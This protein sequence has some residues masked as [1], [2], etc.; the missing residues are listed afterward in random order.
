MNGQ[1]LKVLTVDD[2]ADDRYLLRINLEHNGCVVI[3]AANGAEGLHLASTCNPDVIISDALMP[4][5]D[6]FHLLRCIKTEES[7]QSIPFI[8]YSAV[9]TGDQEASLAISLGAEA[10]IAKPKE[11][12][13]FWNELQRVLDECKG[14][15]GLDVNPRMMEKKAEDFLQKYSSIVTA[16]LEEKVRE[17]EEAKSLIEEKE[18]DWQETFDAIEG[19]VSINSLDNN[20][21]LANRHCRT[22]L[23]V[24]SDE[25]YSHKCFEL[26]HGTSSPIEDCPMISVMESGQTAEIERFETKLNRWISISCFP[27]RNKTGEVRGVVH[28]A[29]DITDRKNNA[30]ALERSET[31]FRSTFEQAAVGI[32]H[33]SLDGRYIRVNK[34]FSDITGYTH[35]E[36]LSLNYKDVTF[37]DDIEIDAKQRAE[38]I[39]GNLESASV[40]K[41]FIDKIGENHWVN[42][43][44][45]LVRDKSGAPDYFVAVIEDISERKKIEQ[46]L[47]QSQKLEAIGTFAG[48]IAHDFNNILAA[49]IGF[50]EMSLVKMRPDD[51]Q[52]GN[53]LQ[54][55]RAAERAAKLTRDILLYSR[56][57]IQICKIV[58]LNEIVSNMKDFLNRVI[59]EDVDLNVTLA[60]DTLSVKVDVN[61]IEQVLMNLVTNARDAI[62]NGG[63]ISIVVES[64]VMDQE[65][66]ERHGFGVPGSYALLSVADTGKGMDPETINRIFEPFYTTKKVGKG[67]GLGLSVVYG[68]V[69]QHNGYICVDSEPQ[70]GT[71]FKVYLPITL[72][73]KDQG[74]ELIFD[75]Q[76]VL[77]GKET[78]LLAD[79]DEMVREMVKLVLSSFGYTVIVAV[80]GKEAVSQYMN[81]AASIDLLLLDMIMPKMSGKDAYDAIRVHSPGVKVLFFSGYSSEM[82][83]DK[84]KLDMTLPLLSKPITPQELLKKIRQILDS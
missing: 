61:H 55:L 78:I 6:G 58:D 68:I 60:E 19:C 41:R 81:N 10:F 53:L 59:G 42:R 54:I 13:V 46:Q 80:D 62:D 2:N 52:R 4:V 39:A 11:P 50:G 75:A 44:I 34:K 21:H 79:D 40:E 9:Y 26:F 29:K 23:G 36:L 38:L 16:K 28:F 33:T 31:L 35:D 49:I 56:K 5:M 51:A 45:S 72:D 76:I 71:T 43:T 8:F 64:E 24:T 83:E 22:M 47:F 14:K 82:I 84:K 15:K 18:Q 37:Q 57:Q 69:R 25:L 48:G 70:R 77:T 67:T 17:L 30:L 73:H 65:F 63:E 20:V 32:S 12:E 66:V 27:L 1:P 74:T 3:E 7:L